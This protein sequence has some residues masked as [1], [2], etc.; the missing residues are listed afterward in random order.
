[1]KSGLELFS[2]PCV[3]GDYQCPYICL[4]TTPSCAWGLSGDMM[5]VTEIDEWDLWQVH[6]ADSDHIKIR[7]D[8]GVVI[9]EI[10]VLNAVPADRVWWVAERRDMPLR[11]QRGNR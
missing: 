5:S 9:Q 6:V 3:S 7:S 8:L 2:S 1:M 4:A 10:R 11:Q